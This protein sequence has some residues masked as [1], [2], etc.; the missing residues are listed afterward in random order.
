[1]HH[2]Y[3]NGNINSNAAKLGSKT[4][5]SREYYSSLTTRSCKV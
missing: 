3:V 2:F 1:M 4:A 5:Y